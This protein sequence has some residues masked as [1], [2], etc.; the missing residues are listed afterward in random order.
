MKNIE[1]I[2]NRIGFG[3]AQFIYKKGDFKI[4]VDEHVTCKTA[5]RLLFKI[6]PSL[7]PNIILAL[8]QEYGIVDQ[9]TLDE[10]WEEDFLETLEY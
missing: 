6:E 8:F 9:D 5:G 1:K 10:M 7:T 4:T 2:L 3:Q